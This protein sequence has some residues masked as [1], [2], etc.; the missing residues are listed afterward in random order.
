ELRCFTDMFAHSAIGR[1]DVVFD[2]EPEAVSVELVSG[3]YY[4]VLGVSALAGRT[5]ELDIDR[6]PTPVAVISHAYWQRRFGLDPAVVGRSFRWHNRAFTIIGITPPEF[7]G[8]V[9]GKR[10]EIPL[11]LSMASEI[12]ADPAWLTSD[13]VR[14]L[15]GMG[16]LSA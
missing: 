9:P 4:S 14:W 12:L 15:E 13:S 3:S 16:R 11:P 1:R 5:F 10:P 7:Q 8:V 2:E 6:S